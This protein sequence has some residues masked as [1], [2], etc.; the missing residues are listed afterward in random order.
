MTEIICT[1]ITSISGIIVAALS[2]QIKKANERAERYAKIRQRDSLLSMRMMDAI[3]KLSVVTANAL[4]GGENNGNV[5]EAKEDAKEAAH[6][7]TVFL[8]EVTADQVGK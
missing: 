8:Q 1:L 2:I 7:Y 6:D 5:A 4:T 3:L